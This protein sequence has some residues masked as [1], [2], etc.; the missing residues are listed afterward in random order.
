MDRQHLKKVYMLLVIAAGAAAV[1]YSAVYLPTERLDARFVVLVVLTI[2]ISSRLTV[3]IPLT[4]GHISVSDTFF[5][6]TILLY[7][8][9]AAVLLAAAEALCSATRFS[10]KAILFNSAMIA[11]STFVTFVVVRTIF[12]D[13]TTLSHGGFSGKFIVVLCVM[14]LVQYVSNSLMASIYTALK[15]GESL[16]HSWTKYYLWASI[17]YFAGASAAGFTVKITE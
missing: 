1:A 13:V 16:W 15:V 12:G 11:C 3:R 14:A 10:R 7:G 17:T 4:T 8:G 9:E 2:A 5:F 6:L